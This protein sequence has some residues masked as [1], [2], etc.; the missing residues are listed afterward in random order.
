MTLTA[1]LPVPLPAFLGIN[2]DSI[3]LLI[4]LFIVGLALVIK[5]GDIFVD[6]AAW[7]SDATGVSKVV[8]G[9]TLVSFATTAPELLTSVIATAKGYNEIAVGNAVGSPVANIGLG[10]AILAM[11][12]P[13][14]VLDGS[15]K[16]K[17]AI[18][19]G[20]TALLLA[21]SLDG[22]LNVTEGLVLFALF[23]VSMV[24][25]IKSNDGDDSRVKIP[26]TNLSVLINIGKFIVGAAALVLGSNLL[27]DN[28]QR[29]AET[30]G[31]PPAVVGVT[32]VAIGT[33]LPEVVTSIT[34][35]IKKQNALSIGNIVGANILD[36]TLILSICSFVSRGNLAV[37]Q[38]TQ[39]LDLPFSLGIMVLAVLPTA[40]GRKL[41]RWQGAIIFAIY[42]VYILLIS[43]IINIQGVTA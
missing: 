38:Q 10:F 19:V 6:A 27:V 3:W 12:T 24:V 26:Q 30:V 21:F 18:M 28:G 33:S 29:L 8:I 17:G 15:F 34:A 31:I 41:Y 40:V 35:V 5:G 32:F 37:P 1:A 25:N 14:A 16:L 42:V 36:N 39:R 43:G 11:F 9:A 7:V 4:I 2:P 20:V 22:R 23:G 13:G